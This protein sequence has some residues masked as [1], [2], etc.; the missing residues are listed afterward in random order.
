[1]SKWYIARLF[2]GDIPTDISGS[3]GSEEE[4]VEDMD[5]DLPMLKGLANLCEA[6]AY[7]EIK[8]GYS[9]YRYSF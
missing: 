9:T 3:G 1:M 5:L 7:V 6:S 2:L 4:A 8:Q